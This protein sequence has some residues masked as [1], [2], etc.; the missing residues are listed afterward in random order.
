MSTT[1][2]HTQSSSNLHWKSEICMFL[3]QVSGYSAKPNILLTGYYSSDLQEQSRR[4]RAATTFRMPQWKILIEL[5]MTRTRHTPIPPFVSFKKTGKDSLSIDVSV[6]HGLP[7]SPDCTPST[8]MEMQHEWRKSI[9][10]VENANRG[11]SEVQLVQSN[12]KMA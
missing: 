12:S 7:R 2:K 8:T 5:H 6:L 9:I 4:Q 3:Q 11:D 10:G 1:S